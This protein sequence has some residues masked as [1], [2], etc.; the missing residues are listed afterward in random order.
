MSGFTRF[1]VSNAFVGEYWS[2]LDDSHYDVDVYTVILPE[3]SEH[4]FAY[5]IV[6]RVGSFRDFVEIVIREEGSGKDITEEEFDSYAST[7]ETLPK[8]HFL[9]Y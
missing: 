3:G 5:K 8:E 1:L 4:R 2:L 9:Q 7:C 6:D